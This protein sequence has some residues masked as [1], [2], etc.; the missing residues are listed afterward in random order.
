MTDQAYTTPPASQERADDTR[1]CID[2][3][4]KLNAALHG[5][6]A[7]GGHHAAVAVAQLPASGA[8]HADV[9]A[10]AR[11][12]EAAKEHGGALARG[13][14]AGRVR[15]VGARGGGVEVEHGQ[16][17]RASGSVRLSVRS[18]WRTL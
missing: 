18:T 11:L 9:G 12:G 7:V 10:G 14:A 16:A 1:S 13:A 8:H 5:D 6:G 4:N 15:G 3:R 2:A 17:A